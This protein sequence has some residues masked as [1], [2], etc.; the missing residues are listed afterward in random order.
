M[1][2]KTKGNNTLRKHLKEFLNKIKPHTTI[3]TNHIVT[4]L[5][6]HNKNY[7]INSARVSSLLKEH[8]NLVTFVKSGIWLK[9]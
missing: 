4:A 1:N 5:S 3:Y 7:N 6:K 8:D 9:I 2:H